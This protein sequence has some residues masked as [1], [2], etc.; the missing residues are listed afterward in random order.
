[1]NNRIIRIWLGG[2]FDPVHYG[3]LSIIHH[4]QTTLTVT[5]PN[6]TIVSALLPTAGSPFKP[7]SLNGK[8]RL[9]MLKL[10]IAEHNPSI[11]I[12]TYELN[13]PTPVY[14]FNTLR[15]FRQLYP[16]DIFIFILGE[17]S[18]LQLPRWYHGFDIPNL[19]HLWIIPR[20]PENFLKNSD[21]DKKF[22]PFLTKNKKNLSNY[23]Q[24]I[25]YLDTFKAPDISSSQIRLLIKQKHNDQLQ[26]FI[27][28]SVLNYIL[29]NC[30]Y[31]S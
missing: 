11:I 22:F 6:Y 12:D 16:N 29:E 23:S 14:T 20:N 2:S 15:T 18:L 7:H 19:T 25:I 21:I 28:L 10:A 30:L 31:Q 4:V 27:P 17:D 13:Q 24:P 8:H 9:A 26:Q 1:M 3:H 5:F